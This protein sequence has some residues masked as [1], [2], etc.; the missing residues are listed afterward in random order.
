MTWTAP[1]TGGSAIT[2]YQ[3]LNGSRTLSVGPTVRK[4]TLTG[5]AKNTK[6]RVVVRAQNA[7]GWSAYAL[8]AVRHHQE[9]VSARPAPTDAGHATATFEAMSIDSEQR[10]WGSWHV[11][12]VADG[13]KIKRIHVNP[14]SRLSLQSHEHRSEHWVVI[15]GEATCEINGVESVVKHDESID[16]PLGAQAPARQPGRRGARHRRGAAR[17][18]H[19]RGRH[20]PLR[21]RLR[22]PRVTWSARPALS[23]RC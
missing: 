4:A 18:L 2:G 3:L 17:C 1:A 13:Y 9:V 21:G 6:T 7:V 20:L 12:D 10:P 8:L 22:A 16:V 5:L 23:C 15:Q 11:I 14:G 19:R